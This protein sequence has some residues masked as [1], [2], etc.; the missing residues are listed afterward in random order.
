M[1]QFQH[2]M[3]NKFGKSYFAYGKKKSMARITEIGWNLKT[4]G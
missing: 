4:V 1:T 3:F 2:Q